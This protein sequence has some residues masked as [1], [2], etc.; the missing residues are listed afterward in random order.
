MIHKADKMVNLNIKHVLIDLFI[1]VGV[2]AI[3]FFGILGD[4]FDEDLT[5]SYVVMLPSFCMIFFLFMNY[6]RLYNKSTLLYTNKVIKNTAFSFVFSSAVLF[7]YLFLAYNTTFSRLFLL[8]F[9]SVTFIAIITEKFILLEMRKVLTPKVNAIYVGDVDGKNDVYE[10]FLRYTQLSGFEF[11]IIG[12]ININEIKIGGDDYLGELNDFEMIL[13][14]YPCNQVIFSQSI[15]G[16]FDLEPFLNITNEMGIIS[17][18]LLD[19]YHVNNYKWY[20]SSFGIFPML[21]FYNVSIDPVLLAIKRL[22]DI[23]GSLA[24]IILASP[25]MLITALAIKIESP[26]TVL[27]KQDRVGLN[28]KKFKILKFRSMCN[29]AEKKK[30]ELIAQNEMGDERLFKMKDDP[31]VTKVGKFIRKTSIDELPQFF[32]VLKGDMSLVGT[33][34]PTVSEVELYNRRHFRRISIKPG[35]TGI[36]QTSGRNEIKDFEQIV[37]MDVTYIDNWSL[38]LDFKLM[39]KTIGVL[40]NSK[41]AY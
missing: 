3:A 36:W 23:I 11:S 21:T 18:V 12:Y 31:R 30:K 22:V 41:G 6:Y 38:L 1:I 14:K 9:I 8:F 16:K 27:F 7:I 40:L 17:R 37:Q 28:G 2:Y 29:D 13:R 10:N 25:L 20:V 5:L 33:R 15:L 32:N 39:L 34:P 4:R 24:G 35:I 26:G 19:V